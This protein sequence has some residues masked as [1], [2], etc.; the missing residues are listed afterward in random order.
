MSHPWGAVQFTSSPNIES[1]LSQIR[2][3]ARA[4][5]SATVHSFNADQY[6]DLA[7]RIC[8]AIGN[9]VNKRLPM[10]PNS[11]TALIGWVGGI[12]REHA[13]EIFTPNYDLLL[14]EAFE[15]ALVPYFDGFCGASLPFFDAS[16]TCFWARLRSATIA[17]RR[18]RSSADTRGQTI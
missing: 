8:N 9:I 15:R 11:F 7:Q 5:G 14:E 17:S 12:P 2:L 18:A 6:D 13:V 4:I 16:A 1:I 3:L 10:E